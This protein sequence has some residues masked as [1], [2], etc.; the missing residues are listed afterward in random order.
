MKII[1]KIALLSIVLGLV[2][3]A[4]K[5]QKISGAY[6]SPFKY[7]N[8]DCEQIAE[9]LHYVSRKTEE[10][11]SSLKNEAGKDTAQAAGFTA[12]GF[13]TLGLGWLGLATLE[14]GDGAEAVEYANLKGEFNALRR[15][16]L[17]K[18]CNLDTLPENYED[19]G[20]PGESKPSAE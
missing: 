16:S 12:L 3:C 7:R 20:K 13:F 2:G 1:L 14:G 6:V 10:L 5:P 9:E 19:I 11:Y 4:T 18:R 15:A 17:D 8:H